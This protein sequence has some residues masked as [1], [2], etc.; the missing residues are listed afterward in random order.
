MPVDLE[1]LAKYK[2]KEAWIEEVKSKTFETEMRCHGC[3]QVIVHTFLE[4]LGVDNLLVSMAASPFAAGVALTGNLCGALIGGQ[5][6]LG[7][8][9]GRRDIETGMPGILE[10]IKPMRKLVKHFSA[11]Q[12]GKLN[13]RDITGADLADPHEAEDYFAHGGLRRCATLM[14]EVA[15]FVAELLYEEY[16][17][18]HGA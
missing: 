15:A 17:K 8:F 5:M 2:D 14:S 12:E 6:V 13:C 3:A 16:Q 9:F 11:T 10:G 4:A 1:A 7:L 18:K